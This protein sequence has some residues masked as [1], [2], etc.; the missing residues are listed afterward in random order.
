MVSERK[1]VDGMAHS[2]KN[3]NV[4]SEKVRVPKIRGHVDEWL[5]ARKN[6][7]KS[8]PSDKIDC[9]NSIKWAVPSEMA[10]YGMSTKSK[11]ENWSKSVKGGCVKKAQKCHQNKI[12]DSQIGKLVCSETK[13]GAVPSELDKPGIENMQKLEFLAENGTKVGLKSI[14]NGMSV[15]KPQHPQSRNAEGGWGGG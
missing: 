15:K 3:V 13:I 1:S 8:G 11:F 10:E 2:E 14:K 6:G 5:V 7:D 9:D 12:S 4:N